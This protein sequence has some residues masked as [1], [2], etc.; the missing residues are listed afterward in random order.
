MLGST[1]T[2]GGTSIV[3]NGEVANS[4][5]PYDSM[6]TMGLSFVFHFS[7]D[8]FNLELGIIKQTYKWLS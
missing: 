4:P 8:I 2:E 7:I 5:A 3:I 1:T 6:P